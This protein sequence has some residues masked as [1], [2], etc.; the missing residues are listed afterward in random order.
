MK[1]AVIYARYS[2]DSQTEQSIEGQLRVCQDYAKAN[3]ILIVDT[4]I[5]RAMTGTNDLRPDFQRMIKD[6]GKRQWDYVLVYKLD[7]FS[8]DKYE[9]TIH[10]HTLK[11]N[12]VKLLSAMENIPDSPEGII[13]ESLLEGMNQYYS[14]E[15]AQKINRGLKESWR[16]G[17]TTG[18]KIFFGYDV[19][20]KKCV[21][22]PYE[23]DI[24]R[25]AFTRYAQG[26]KAM[27]IVRLFKE[28]GYRR[29]NGQ[30]I[31]V[32]YLYR[33][34][35]D[36]RYTGIVE[37]HGVVY[38][39]I[40]P[41][42]ISDELWQAVS[43]ITDENKIAP[44]RKKEVFDFLLSGKLVCGKCKHRMIGISGTSKTGAKHY[45]Y[46]CQSVRQ[47]KVKCETTPIRKRYIEDLVIDTTVHLLRDTAD[48]N[49]LAE[50]IYKVHQHETA[51]DTALKALE[52]KR[53]ETL[54]A[55]NNIIKAIEQGIITEAT[56]SRLTELETEV[57]HLEFEITRERA[58]HHAFLTV[59]QIEA[60]LRQFV[61]EDPSDIQVRKLLVNTFVR[62]VLL[63]DDNIVI[64]YN[65]TDDPTHPKVTKEQAEREE[66]QIKQA[67]RILPPTSSSSIWS[68]SP[69]KRK[70]TARC[71]FDLARG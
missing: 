16:K 66:K 17:Q 70:G 29:K 48:V 5:D 2:S 43:A 59:D 57:A 34:L 60:Y 19:V 39:G 30:H 63:Y 52:Q 10:K 22:N 53:K 41:R 55:Q 58:T 14:A 21:I 23:G 13:L 18:G 12:G 44:S 46:A 54:R 42:I 25:E 35:H 68:C 6:S 36:I 50:E 3:D 62:E 1:T 15:L 7:R 11:E 27:A 24:V 61:F 28:R 67:K 4:Y 56:K 32:N 33:I 9:T 69:P 45:Y 40:F 71:L 37:H 26:Y 38:D 51:D 64:T 65:F 20:D 47:T 49:A 8:R 31:D